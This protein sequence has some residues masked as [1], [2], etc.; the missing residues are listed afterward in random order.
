MV[1]VNATMQ[2]LRLPPKRR[3]MRNQVSVVGYIQL[4]FF[5][6]FGVIWNAETGLLIIFSIIPIIVLV[7]KKILFV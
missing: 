1:A 4:G 6:F 7:N 3:E 2:V 5:L